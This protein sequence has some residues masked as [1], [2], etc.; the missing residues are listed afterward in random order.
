M[1]IFRT[2]SKSA[3]FWLDVALITAILACLCYIFFW[4]V[5]VAGNSMSPTVSMGDQL[6]VS[7]FLGFVGNYT[8]GDLVMATIEVG[9]Q[10][11]IVI[12]R[13]AAVPADHLVIMGDALFI[14]G[15]RQDWPFFEGN[16]VFVDIVLGADEYFL[17]G[18]N[19]LISNDSRH[20]GAVS[21]RQIS[22]TIVMRYFPLSVIEIF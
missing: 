20:F 4:P 2:K 1:K 14:N 13:I 9:G 18:D 16:N 10:A 3:N 6:I 15:T 22:A 19:A 5:R 11:E 17:L 21:R 12:K 7:R 8:H